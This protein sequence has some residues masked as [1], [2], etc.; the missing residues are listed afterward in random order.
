MD[1][2]SMGMGWD[3]MTIKFVEEADVFCRELKLN[4][5]MKL[6]VCNRSVAAKAKE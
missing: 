6:V 5:P 1:E 4:L 3:E 2:V